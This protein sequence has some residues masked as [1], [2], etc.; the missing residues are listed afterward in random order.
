MKMVE[1]NGVEY[2]TVM[3]TAVRVIVSFWGFHI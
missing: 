2:V 3:D 1:I